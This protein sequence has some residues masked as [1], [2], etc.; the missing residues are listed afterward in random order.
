MLKKWAK[1]AV[2]RSS[3]R[4]LLGCGL[5]NATLK[6]LLAIVLVIAGLKMIFT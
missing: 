6:R 4:R 1:I 3:N 2:D 5:G